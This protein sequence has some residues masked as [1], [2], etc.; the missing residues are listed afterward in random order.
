MDRRAARFLFRPGCRRDD[1]P[2]RISAAYSGSSPIALARLPTASISRLRW[3]ASSS[4]VL[5]R[6]V[7]PR[8]LSFACTSGA[9]SA[10]RTSPGAEESPPGGE[11]PESGKNF[12]DGGDCGHAGAAPAVHDRKRPDLRHVRREERV[13]RKPQGHAAGDPVVDH[14]GE[15]GLRV[16]HV[17]HVDPGGELQR[18]ARQMEHRSGPARSVFELARVAHIARGADREADRLEILQHVEREILV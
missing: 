5:A 1:H 10:A 16:G 18:L 14:L 11:G 7:S 6:V 15:I 3:A 17:E 8:S 9:F 13:S 4:G 2:V 12:S